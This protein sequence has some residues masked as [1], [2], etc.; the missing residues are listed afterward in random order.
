MGVGL[1]AS[2]GVLTVDD[3]VSP[4][5]SHSE[6]DD[7][8]IAYRRHF[9]P[10][11]RIAYLLVGSN[12]V[13]EDLV[14]DVF[15][16]CSGRLAQLEDPGMYLRTS[17]VNACRRYH[18]RDLGVVG[19]SAE[20][21][22]EEPATTADAVAVRRALAATTPKRRAALVLRYYEDLTHDDIAQVLGCRPATARSLVRRGLNDLR[23]A[24]DGE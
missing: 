11:M 20:P 3:R 17:V 12:A 4:R 13:A 24:F 22:A 6:S 2:V 23:G 10:L 14:H 21:I 8:E 15:V 19:Q 5:I 1:L 7:L 9:A 16:R 18:R